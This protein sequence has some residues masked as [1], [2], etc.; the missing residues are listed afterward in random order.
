[1]YAEQLGSV[2]KAKFSRFFNQS[3]GVIDFS[4]IKPRNYNHKSL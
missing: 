4:L 1:M 3:I 2:K